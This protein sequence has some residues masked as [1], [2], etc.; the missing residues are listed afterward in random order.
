MTIQRRPKTGRPKTGSVKWIVRYRDPS[1]KEHSRSFSTEREAKAY[2]AATSRDLAHGMWINPADQRISL[3]T[4][5]NEWLAEATK[6]NTIANR[7]VFIANLGDLAD[8][9]VHAIRASHI[10]TWRNTL[11]TVRPWAGGRPLAESTAANM[12]G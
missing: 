10:T 7:K 12:V 11:V 4:L 9:P 2:D 1:G 6:S 8:M 3:R 5:A